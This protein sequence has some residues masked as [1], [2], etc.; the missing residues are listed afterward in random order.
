MQDVRPLKDIS[1]FPIVDLLRTC[2][3]FSLPGTRE[4]RRLCRHLPYV[5]ITSQIQS[6]RYQDHRGRSLRE[7]KLH[8]CL[9]GVGVFLSY[10]NAQYELVILIEY[11][12]PDKSRCDGEILSGIVGGLLYA[13]CQAS[14]MQL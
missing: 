14:C 3:E 8:K 4:H 6:H 10:H 9:L 5:K 12:L 13:S 2:V 11:A 7:D 1:R